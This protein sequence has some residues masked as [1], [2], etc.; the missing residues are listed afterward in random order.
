[1]MPVVV[2]LSIGCVKSHLGLP[3]LQCVDAVMGETKCGGSECVAPNEK[4]C[5][6]SGCHIVAIKYKTYWE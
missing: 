5:P 3:L 4:D 6:K 1:M 2:V